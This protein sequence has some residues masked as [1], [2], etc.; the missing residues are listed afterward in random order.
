MAKLDRL[1]LATKFVAALHD[2]SLR[3]PASWHRVSALAARTG[4]K[5]AEL[6]Q[7]VADSVAAGLVEQQVDSPSLVSLTNKGWLFASR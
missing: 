1:A 3:K 5:G 2:I 4:I 7:V 6:A